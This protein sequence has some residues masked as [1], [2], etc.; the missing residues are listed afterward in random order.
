M[1]DFLFQRIVV[2]LQLLWEGQYE[3]IEMSA[4]KFHAPTSQKKYVRMMH[5]LNKIHELL[6]KD[7]VITKRELYY[8]L[9]RHDGGTMEQIDEAIQTIVVML[10]IP[11]GQLR[12]LATSKGLIAGNLTYTNSYGIEIDCSASIHGEQIPNE[13]DDM[14]DITSN[15]KVVIVVEKDATFQRLMQ[16]DFLGFINFDVL[17]ITGKGVPDLSTR[18]L[19]YRLANQDLTDA[20]F[21]CLVDGDP[22]GIAIMLIYKASIFT[23]FKN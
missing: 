12:I 4:V 16:E 3:T 19:I 21:L 10:Q 23:F 22:Y 11:R 2:I 15:A 14:F 5:I 17:L 20:V 18:K 8:Q 13:V 9:L 1:L 7:E 6:V